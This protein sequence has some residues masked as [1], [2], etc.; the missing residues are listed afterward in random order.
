M[1][2]TSE[3]DRVGQI[4]AKLVEFESLMSRQSM[5]LVELE[6]LGCQAAIALKDNGDGTSEMSLNHQIGPA[7]G[8]H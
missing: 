2:F 7:P 4:R 5:I 3:L 8:S 1:S 6:R